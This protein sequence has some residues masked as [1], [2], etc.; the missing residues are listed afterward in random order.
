M[1]A[2]RAGPMKATEF[3]TVVTTVLS[4][5]VKYVDTELSP[6][7]AKATD[8]YT[9]EPFGNEEDG[10]SQVVLTEV[11]DAVD[12]M[13]P[14]LQRIL[15]GSEH[16]VEFCPT[17]S[18]NVQQ[19]EQATDYV[20]YV[21]EQDNGGFLENLSVLKDGMIRKIGT[22]KWVWEPPSVKAVKME[23]LTDEQ[24]EAMLTQNPETKLLYKQKD[25]D[26]WT[27]ELTTPDAEGRV[28]IYA[29]PPE[30]VIFSRNARNKN[31]ATFFG[32]RTEKTRGE[33]V[34]MGISESDIDEYGKPADGDAA[35]QSNPENLARRGVD[36][37]MADETAG[38]AN[39]KIKYC[40]G[41]LTID[42]N[43][44]SIAESRRLCTI[45]EKYYPVVNDP[46]DES[47]GFAVFT[48]MPEPHTLIG[49]SIYDKTHDIQRINSMI[50]RTALDSA[51][52][53]AFPRH[54]ILEGQVST[55]DVMNTAIGAPIRERVMNAVRPLETPFIAD[56]LIPFMTF[57]Q[58]IVERRTGNKGAMGLDEDALQSTGKEAVGAV[59]TGTQ[60]QLELIARV[61]AE[62]TLKPL[63]IGVARMLA[64]KQ[65]KGRMVRLRGQWVE[66]NPSTWDPKMDCVVNVALGSTYPEKKISTL[67]A[68]AADQKEI[69][70]TMG[71][72]NPLV[73]LPMLRNTRAKILQLQGLKDVDSYYLP[74]DPNWQPP[75]APP[76]PP[77]PE[78]LWMQAEKEMNHTKAMKEL[79]IKADELQLKREQSDRD[80]ELALRKI[81]A[82][83]LTK[84][85]A[86]DAQFHA[87]M[88]DTQMTHEL[89]SATAE[90]E[91]TMA[92]HQHVHAQTLEVDAHEHGKAMAEDAQAHQ[93]SMAEQEPTG[94]A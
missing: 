74:I 91:L 70:T 1:S 14:S 19:A 33:L 73:S 25:G 61:F 54:A 68:V 79:A 67:M 62:M 40:E 82:D 83:V 10:R 17:N 72:T 15:C 30:E 55:A 22:Y 38:E 35:L 52:A 58:D 23:G 51:A 89:D 9:G 57:M 94:E 53:S 20:R 2:K 43:G 3:E 50:L 80:Y 11:A 24:L 21:F 36:G 88:T 5:C 60:Q 27:V 78:V 69:I 85:Y 75:P 90:A 77:N 76:A 45:G 41:L 7:R 18:T 65:P 12:G 87:Q 63:F 56:K 84:K 8:Y 37:F 4:D 44:D 66:V 31:G 46:A 16:P 42:Y 64:A 59:L 86:A 29:I 71:L 34:A 26:T 92:A 39:T 81:E 6:A 32:Q 49:R 28:G 48:P 13:I 47:M 93:Q